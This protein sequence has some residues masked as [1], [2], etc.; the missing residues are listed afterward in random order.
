MPLII[1]SLVP[2]QNRI[3]GLKGAC[4]DAGV[5]LLSPQSA[6]ASRPVNIAVPLAK[7]FRHV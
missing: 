5:S 3:I 2:A 4:F 6:E 1:F 7:D